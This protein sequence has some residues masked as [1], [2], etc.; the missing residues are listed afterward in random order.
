VACGRARG[1]RVWRLVRRG[2][3]DHSWPLVT[4]ECWLCFL[5]QIKY[6]RRLSQKEVLAKEQNTHKVKK[7]VW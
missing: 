3:G 4:A 7:R 6:D 1:M 2:G 5:F